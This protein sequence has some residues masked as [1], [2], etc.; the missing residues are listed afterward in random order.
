M[1]NYAPVSDYM[2]FHFKK[3]DDKIHTP[4]I[5]NEV[6][7][8]AVT[9]E[10]HYTVYL[11]AYSD[12][13][14]LQQLNTI[15]E[16]SWQVFSKHSKK[17]YREGN[18]HVL[19]VDNTGFLRSVAACTGVVTGGGFEGPAEALFLGKK[20]LAV[21]MK[22]QYEQ[23]C[24]ALALEEMGVPVIWNEKKFGTKLKTFISTEHNIRV[25]YP[26]ETEEIIQNLIN[27]H[28]EKL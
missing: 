2:A 3:Y 12:E 8:L 11:P 6:R 19:P 1:Q 10:G 4:V 26:D 28:A 9:D 17:V 14:I 16:I 21:P 20:I 27:I 5:R 24:N 18:V 15:P 13:F 25:N 7:N 22:N 23:Q